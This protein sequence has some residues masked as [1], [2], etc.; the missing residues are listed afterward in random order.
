MTITSEVKF[1]IVL[2]GHVEASQLLTELFTAISDNPDL[3]K[4]TALCEL[5]EKEYKYLHN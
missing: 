3:R 4:L 2:T 5:L 1:T